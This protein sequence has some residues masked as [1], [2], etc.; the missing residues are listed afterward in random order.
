MNIA[1]PLNNNLSF[2]HSNPITAP[3]F[4]IY[5][6]DSKKS[7]VRTSLDSIV[8]NPLN[9]TN[10]GNYTVS[11]IECACNVDKCSDITHISEH[12]VL[13]ESIGD[14]EYLLADH[15]CDNINRALLNGGITIYKI[16]P[17]IH[18]PD[19]AIKNFLLGASL[20]S[21]IKQIYHAS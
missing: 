13:L 1:I 18:K 15:Y 21:T 10:Q 4:A 7:R 3:K 5:H 2:Y 14:C 17:F 20:A 16:P 12:Y 9:S 8:D 6:I 11:Q 19:N